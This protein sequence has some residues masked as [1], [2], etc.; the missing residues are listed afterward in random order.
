MTRRLGRRLLSKD[1]QMNL[2]D[3]ILFIEAK[4]AGKK[5]ASVLSI[6]QV[7]RTSVSAEASIKEENMGE[8]HETYKYCGRDGHGKIPKT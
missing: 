1:P 3:T 6:N 4:E 5:S 7:P 2:A 8:G